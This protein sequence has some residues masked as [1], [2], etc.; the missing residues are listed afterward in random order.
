MVEDELFDGAGEGRP[1]CTNP[2]GRLI[3][4][5][6]CFY[7]PKHTG[8]LSAVVLNEWHLRVVMQSQGG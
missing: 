7:I 1:G 6:A 5:V 2:P 4:I 8:F 3:D